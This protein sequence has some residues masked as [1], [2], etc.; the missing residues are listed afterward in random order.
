M[1]K[2]RC[3]SLR[4]APLTRGGSST[5]SLH[6]GGDTNREQDQRRTGS[7]NSR[8]GR[9]WGVGR[10]SPESALSYMAPGGSKNAGANHFRVSGAM[11]RRP[12][13]SPTSSTAL[14]AAWENSWWVR[15][16][17]PG[18]NQAGAGFVPIVGAMR[19]EKTI[20][21]DESLRLLIAMADAFA[22][23]DDQGAREP[24]YTFRAGRELQIQHP[25]FPADDWRQ[26]DDEL[27]ERLASRGLVRLE[28]GDNTN[29]VFVTVDGER[30]AG[31]ARRL[32]QPEQDVPEG[33]EVD[34]DW[35]TVARPVLEA[36]C[37]AWRVRGAPADGV[38]T[39]S[40]AHDVGEGENIVRQTR[41]AVAL[42]VR[43]GYLDAAGSMS[44][45]DAP[46]TVVVTGRGMQVVGGWPATT[47]EAASHALLVAL[48]RAIEE[49]TEPERRT[50][51]TRLREVL[52][53]LGQGTLA[54]VL[55]RVVTGGL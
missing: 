46:A 23:R 28:Y 7:E 4:P 44:V 52:L 27:L 22:V 35:E 29:K 47:G 31:E 5:R 12:P 41:R 55:A 16:Q 11:S 26:V 20:N 43:E 38:V 17:A 53:D 33:R 1:T 51:L 48:D 24:L 42:L 54:E 6:R 18:R 50:K 34:L 32:L 45:D 40:V 30:V 13:G 49:T 21:L 36:V 9:G 8:K 14:L 37:A 39:S 25:A 10:K 15:F 3:G 2:S 19:D